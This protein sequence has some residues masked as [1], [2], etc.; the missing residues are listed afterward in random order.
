MFVQKKQGRDPVQH[1]NSIPEAMFAGVRSRAAG[2]FDSTLKQKRQFAPSLKL[3]PEHHRSS[4]RAE[5]RSDDSPEF[6]QE[7]HRRRFTIFETKFEFFG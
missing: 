5:N 7:Q 3:I 4:I 1:H 2:K 6:V